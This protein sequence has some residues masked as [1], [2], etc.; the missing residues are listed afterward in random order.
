MQQPEI[1]IY[2]TLPTLQDAAAQ[3]IVTLAAAA[4][5][6][7]GRFLTAISGGSAPPGVFRRLTAEPL[8]HQVDWSAWSVLWADERYVPFSS[9][10]S[11]YLLA[12]A[13]LLDHVPIPSDQVYP[14]ATYYD[15][16]AAA[17]AI[18]DRLTANLLDL[19]AGRIDL[20]LLG[21]GPDG[22]TASLFPGHPALT[23]DPDAL[24]LVVDQAPK[25]PPLRITLTAKALNTARHVLFLVAGADKAPLVHAALREQPDPY[26]LPACLI[27]PPDGAVTWMLDTAAAA[28]L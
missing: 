10:D 13:S 19:H 20:A 17:A 8:S 7:R 26:R 23:A 21:M 12:R 1:L 28:A 25:P 24:A 5:A 14:V 16:P 6:E 11:N 15:D 18:Y 3:R 22:H 27:R 2:P 9:D 4:V